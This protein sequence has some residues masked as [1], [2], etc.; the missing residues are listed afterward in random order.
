MLK[1]I[2]FYSSLLKREL[3]D[4]KKTTHIHVLVY[5]AIEVHAMGELGCIASNKTIGAEVGI[6]PGSASNSISDLRKAG[7]ISIEFD[8]NNQRGKITPLLQIIV[9]PH[10]TMDPPPLANVPPLH[11]PM[12]IE[13]NR[14]YNK[15]SIG[16]EKELPPFATQLSKRLF[17]WIEKNYP[18]R[19][20]NEKYAEKWAASIE[21]IHR[22]DKHPIDRIKDVIDWSQQDDFWHQNIKSG[23]TLRK[24]FDRLL[25]RMADE[26]RKSEIEKKKNTYVPIGGVARKHEPLEDNRAPVNSDGLK[27]FN[28]MRRA[29]LDKKQSP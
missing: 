26:K 13:Y 11:S 21:K 19:E 22:I 28:D 20:H 10:S 27:K 8:K 15:K 24:Q 9:P 23:D 29:L 4:G 18:D 2:P 12:D 7:W 3:A 1:N 5:G 6:T 25:D 14:E 17:K 16:R